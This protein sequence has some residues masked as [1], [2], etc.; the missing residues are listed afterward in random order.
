MEKIEV[1]KY[2]SLFPDSMISRNR[3]LYRQTNKNLNSFLKRNFSHSINTY[4][5][6]IKKSFPINDRK[7][8]L[9]RKSSILKEKPIISEK[10][11]LRTLIESLRHENCV[12]YNYLDNTKGPLQSTVDN[13]KKKKVKNFNMIYNNNNSIKDTN[14]NNI[15]LLSFDSRPISPKSNFFNSSLSLQKINQQK[16]K[17]FLKILENNKNTNL[18]SFS[19]NKNSM[20]KSRNISKN[21]SDLFSPN[22]T[23]YKSKMKNNSLKLEYDSI[24]FNNSDKKKGRNSLKNIKNVKLYDETGENISNISDKKFAGEQRKF[25]Q[26]IYMTNLLSQIKLFQSLN[27]F[28]VNESQIKTNLLSPSIFQ[29]DLFVKEI[30]RAF[31]QN[32]Y[33]YKKYPFQSCK[34]ETLQNKQKKRALSPQHFSSDKP[35]YLFKNIENLFKNVNFSQNFIKNIDFRLGTTNL[36]RILEFVVQVKHKISDID[37]EFKD[38]TINYQRN[39]GKFFIYKGSGVYSGHLSSILKGDKIVKQVIKFDSI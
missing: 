38:E 14:T 32:D 4:K 15:N 6:P 19:F 39:I 33:F 28:E 12:S 36:K 1:K 31:K 18:N 25:H 17:K 2:K 23:R 34:F 30:K 24:S 5:F 10:P 29:R 3:I 37:E 20:K 22:S 35:K 8:P 21:G 13:N 7:S 16:A 26:K 27:G 11:N 9:R